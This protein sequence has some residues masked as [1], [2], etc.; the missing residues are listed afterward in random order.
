[1]GFIIL[2][3]SAFYSL[4]LHLLVGLNGGLSKIKT[5]PPDYT[6]KHY[7]SILCTLKESSI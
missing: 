3:E 2:E 1:M 6:I 4:K 5:S 7:Y